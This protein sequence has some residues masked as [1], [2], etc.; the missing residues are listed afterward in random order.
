MIS[1]YY[2]TPEQE[3][4]VRCQVREGASTL[5]ELNLTVPEESNAKAICGSWSKKARKFM[6]I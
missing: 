4:T 2:K 3:Y 5:I 1:D 6:L